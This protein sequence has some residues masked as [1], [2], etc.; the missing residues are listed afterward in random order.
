[1]INELY[2][3]KEVGEGKKHILLFDR[4]QYT[5]QG[6]RAL[7]ENTLNATITI[8]SGAHSS[9][10]MSALIINSQIDM[11]ICG[12]SGQPEDF[13]RLLTIP[14]HL[15]TCKYILLTNKS[16]SALNNTFRTAGFCAVLNK[17]MPIN[18]LNTRVQKILL[19]PPPFRRTEIDPKLYLSTERQILGA[20]LKGERPAI[21]AHRM[22]ISYRAVSRFK[23]NALRRAGLKSLNEI[24]LPGPHR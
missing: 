1:M 17:N 16:S 21:I 4:C 9:Q 6:L 5:A 22:G 10:Q 13:L 19:G 11:V 14:S 15:A 24:L 2:A 8:M 7:C 23:Q 18:A 3:G 20:L 12:M